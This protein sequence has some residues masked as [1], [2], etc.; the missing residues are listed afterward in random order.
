MVSNGRGDMI[1]VTNRMSTNTENERGEII[2]HWSEIRYVLLAEL[3]FA[4][5]FSYV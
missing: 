2:F 3:K 5:A 4:N 1:Q